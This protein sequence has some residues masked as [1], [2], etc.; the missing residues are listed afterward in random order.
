MREMRMKR[1]LRKWYIVLPLAILILAIA[2]WLLLTYRPDVA[3]QLA[4]PLRRIL[5]NER[6]AQLESF[7][8]TV[9]DKARQ[10]QYGLGLAEPASP[11]EAPSPVATP[12]PTPTATP[13]PTLPPSATPTALTQAGD[14][15]ATA[16]SSPTPTQT[17]SP[18]ATPFPQWTL[19]NL[20]PFG[21]LAGEGVWQPYLTNPAGEVVALRAFLQPDPERPYTSVGVVAFDLQ[22][23][24]LHY[25][26]GSQEPALPGGPRGTG[27]I[28]VEDMQP[29]RLLATFNGGFLA[30]HG[31]YGAMSGGLVALPAKLGYGTVA[32][33]ESGELQIGE[34][35]V[36]INPDAAYTFWRQNARMVVHNG[37]INERVYNSSIITWGGSINGDIVTWRSGIGL[38][39]NQEVLY[40]LA[41]PSVSM[42]VLAQAM[43]AAGVHNGILLDINA[44]WVHF[45]AIHSDGEELRAE[46]LFGEG[47]ETNVDRY[48]KQSGRDFFYITVRE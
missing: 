18:T 11:W 9:Q 24:Q 27:R 39:E 43:M 44:T 1:L 45:A 15:T 6:V 2:G 48:L 31:E 8:F 32:E 23:T 20:E 4:N 28:P 22:K 26:L 19:P 47:M 46:P 41:G 10:A 40:Y 34:W 33:L 30:T 16:A 29:G 21:T 13:S 42:P 3:A 5:G 17:P 12:A 37:Q 36:E 25:V 35:G 38:D 7:A 14:S